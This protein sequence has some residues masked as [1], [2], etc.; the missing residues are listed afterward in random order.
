MALYA[1]ALAAGDAGS[2]EATL[3]RAAPLTIPSGGGSAEAF[4]V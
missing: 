3:R 2:V 4:S 1:D